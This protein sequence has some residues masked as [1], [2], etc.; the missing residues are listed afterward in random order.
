[1]VSREGTDAAAR[2]VGLLEPAVRAEGLALDGVTVTPAGRRRVVRVTVDLP[3]DQTGSLD[4]DR[5][6]DA[7]RAVSAVLD[8]AEPLGQTPYVLE[9]STPGVDRPLTEPRHWRRARTR[10][11]TV[12]VTRDGVTSPLTGR[13]GEVGDGGVRLLVDGE[14]VDVPWAD[15]GTGRV[16]VEFS[17][18]DGDPEDGDPEDG[19]L[20]D[21]EES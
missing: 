6:A 9:V 16:Q 18:P 2:L 1:M 15:L 20:L 8:D 11:V 5:V 17:R 13:V 10:L 3:E 4:L 14:S 12:P 7:S 19:D 21:E